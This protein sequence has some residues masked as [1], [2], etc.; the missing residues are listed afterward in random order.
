MDVEGKGKSPAGGL[1]ILSGKRLIGYAIGTIGQMAPI[2]IFNTFATNYYN[3]TVGLDPLYTFL[4]MFFGLTTFAISSPIFGTLIDNKNPGKLG[5]RRPFLLLGIPLIVLLMILAWTPPLCPT[6]GNVITNPQY[7]PTAIYFWIVAIALYL[8][9]GLLVSTYL[10][11]LAEQTTDE[12]NRVKVATLQ[13]I[14]S[15]IG[16]VISILLPIILQSQLAD[17]NDPLSL[18]HFNDDGSYLVNTLPYIGIIFGLLGAISFIAVFAS[19]DESFHKKKEKSM[20]NKVSLGE[21]FKRIMVPLKDKNYR[22][23]MGNAFF[24]N[25]AIRV[26]IVILIPVLN[27]VL[28]LESNQFLLF[29][30]AL[31]PFALG[32]YALWTRKI[33]SS[34]LKASYGLSLQV[35]FVMSM[36]IFIFLV[37]MDFLLRFFL[38]AAVMG[39]LISS[40]VGGYLFPNPIVSL[41]VDRAPNFIK[42]EAKKQNTAL[43]GSYF[44]LYIFSYNI[45]QAIANVMLAFIITEQTKD[46]PITIILTIPIAGV[47]VLISYLFLR[48]LK[49]P[50]KPKQ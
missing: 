47:L 34:G 22:Y 4:G 43:S 40:L 1:R 27:F 44:G 36:V 45:S 48:K 20:Q 30:I 39:M 9:Q 11:M 31:L 24:F 33:K 26:L 3:Y 46:D 7:L 16:T 42:E 35:N 13:G 23:W 41:L 12:E 2:G 5:K 49:L 29:F 19:T 25:M 17:P 8:N 21:T 10:S 32:G 38:G 37:P 6:D 50:H 18:Y 14:F 28:L 15:I